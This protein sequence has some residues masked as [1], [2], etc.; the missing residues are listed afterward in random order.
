[1]FPVLAWIQIFSGIW[2]Q[3]STLVYSFVL[4]NFI[5]KLVFL[6]EN[7]TNQLSEFIPYV[8]IFISYQIISSLAELLDN[9]SN[10]IMKNFEGK[11]R[12]KELLYHKLHR[13]GIQ[14]LEDPE[15]ENKLYRTNDALSDI[16][17]FG[18]RIVYVISQAANLIVSGLIV[19]SV[20]PWAL[21]IFLAILIPRT[22]LYNKALKIDW[23]FIR[24]N[25]EKRRKASHDSSVISKVKH[26]HEIVISGAF[27]FFHKRFSGFVDYYTSGIRKNTFKL[28]LWKFA[29]VIINNA[30]IFFYALSFVSLF[31]DGSLT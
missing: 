22:I 16:L 24:D 25:T 29:F 13:I 15:T 2:K 23:K 26:L 6:S 3:I 7:G 28:Y 9:Y 4:A 8:T 20:K 17:D 30:V 5:D 31:I 1:M 11:L 12:L 10:K 21:A 14:E 18:K 27:D 19:F